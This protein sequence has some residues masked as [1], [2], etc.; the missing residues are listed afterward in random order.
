MTAPAPYL[1][2]VDPRRTQLDD[3]IVAELLTSHVIT[4]SS[5][6]L[7]EYAGRKV[8]RARCS[9]CGSSSDAQHSLSAALD[10]L[11]AVCDG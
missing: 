6:D 11:T 7:D 5:T 10:D 3:L 4:V 8:W 1:R 9:A 2:H